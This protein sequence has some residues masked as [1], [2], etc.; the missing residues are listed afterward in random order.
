MILRELCNL[1]YNNSYGGLF[2]LAKGKSPMAVVRVIQHESTILV[3]CL[4]L[5]SGKINVHS[6]EK[7]V[8]PLKLGVFED[9]E[10]FIS[11][12]EAAEARH[13]GCPNWPNCDTEGC[14]AW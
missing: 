6:A 3:E 13:L 8:V 14:G 10:D 1:K 5:K 11:Q 2:R 4:Y 9:D 7:E 12:E